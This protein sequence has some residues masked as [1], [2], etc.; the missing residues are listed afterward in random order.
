[1]NPLLVVNG[2]C[3]SYG[4]FRLEGVEFEVGEGESF[5]LVG[6]S[7]AGKT[8]LLETILGLKRAESGS[9]VCMGVSMGSVPP[10]RMRISYLPQDLALFPHM[11]VM[12]NV[13][14]CTRFLDGTGGDTVRRIAGMLGI[15]HLLDRP[16]ISTLSGGESQRVALARALVAS[17][18]LLVLDEPF[19]ALDRAGRRR[20]NEDLRRLQRR[21]GFAM[22][23]V[24][25]DYE[26][27]LVMADRVGVMRRGRM[28]RSGTPGELFENPRDQW[29]AAFFLF[30]NIL[31]LESLL[32]VFPSLRSALPEGGGTSS[33]G[34]LKAA[35]RSRDVIVRPAEEGSRCFTSME[36][37]RTKDEVLEA[38]CTVLEYRRSAERSIVR[39]VV[40]DL[41]L[42]ATPLAS[43]SEGDSGVLSFDRRAL[44]LVEGELS[45]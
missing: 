40:E 39:V 7:G 20:L 43:M 44:K 35:L 14:F 45:D 38:S 34:G 17:P 16:S 1:M 11:S 10:E 28:L 36:R 13:A 5:A 24:T 6:P 41:E 19:A 2:L 15:E 33:R 32:R 12:E 37:I 42:S 29:E 31:P 30:D 3:V 27:A 26:E 4:A 23:F 21:L 22:V 8:L 18:R 25:H 9:I